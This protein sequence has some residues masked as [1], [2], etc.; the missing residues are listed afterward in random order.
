MKRGIL[1]GLLVGGIVAGLSLGFCRMGHAGWRH[2]E[3][4][5]DEIA[6]TCADAALK[7]MDRERESRHDR[8]HDRDRGRDRDHGGP[9]HDFPHL[10]FAPPPPA[11]PAVTPPAPPQTPA[12]AA[13]KP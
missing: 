9:P 10:G 6:E 4:F 2:H 8:D 1:I 13:P 7:V 12:P 3:K 11:P 5:R